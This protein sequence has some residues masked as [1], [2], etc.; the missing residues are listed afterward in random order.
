MP[1]PLWCST[2]SLPRRQIAGWIL[3]FASNTRPTTVVPLNAVA[4][5]PYP[6]SGSRMMAA[7][8]VV[9]ADAADAVDDA[10]SRVPASPAAAANVL[11]CALTEV[12]FPC[13]GRRGHLRPG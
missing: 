13:G 5:P 8:Q 1:M 11:R 3:P 4:P 6:R 7:E 12:P 10:T 2:V 9:A